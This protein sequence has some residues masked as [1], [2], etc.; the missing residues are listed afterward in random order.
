MASAPLWKLRRLAPRARRII[1]RRK[2]EA[3]VL[4]AYEPTLVPAAEGFMAAYDQAVRAQSRRSKE[5]AEGQSAVQALAVATR[6]WMPLLVRDVAGFDGV[7]VN[8]AGVPDD[9]IEE[10]MRVL[11]IVADHVDAA[12]NALP[13]KDVAHAELDEKLAAA[14]KELAEAEAADA[15]YQQAL[16]ATRATSAVFDTELQAFRRSLEAVLGRKD[17]DYQK[18][19]SQRAAQRDE[20]DDANA[21]LPPDDAEP[22]LDVA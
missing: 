10:S 18:L 7:S 3:P 20:D 19:R 16:A 11:G 13:Y 5:A 4:Q 2:A 8:A 14:R 1:E 21:P 12:G 9:V 17:K 6:G 15:E 22:V